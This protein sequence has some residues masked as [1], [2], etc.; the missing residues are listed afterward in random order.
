[1]IAFEV[2]VGIIKPVVLCDFCHARIIGSGNA[3]WIMPSPIGKP[4]RGPNF[5]FESPIYHTHKHCFHAFDLSYRERHGDTHFSSCELW[6]FTAQ[7]LNNVAVRDERK[8]L[9]IFDSVKRAIES[10]RKP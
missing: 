4:P 5:S 8:A 9:R 6:R 2:E 3:L 10:E 7:M 1:M